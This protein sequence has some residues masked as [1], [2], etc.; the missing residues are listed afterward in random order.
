MEKTGW[1]KIQNN[2][3]KGKPVSC[4]NCGAKGEYMVTFEDNWGRLTVSLCEDCSQK[5]YG[6]LKL[7]SKLIWPILA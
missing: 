2:R 4:A 6:E 7:Q 3:K 5:E 1:E